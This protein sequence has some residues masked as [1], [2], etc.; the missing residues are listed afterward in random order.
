MIIIK[1][2]L[3]KLRMLMDLFRSKLTFTQNLGK[4]LKIEL[5]LLWKLFMI[6]YW[7]IRLLFN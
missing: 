3:L 4:L 2:I 6:S 5:L 7:M 1:K